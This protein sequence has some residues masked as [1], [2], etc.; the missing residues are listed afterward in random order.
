MERQLWRSAE[1]TPNIWL[2]IIICTHMW[3]KYQDWVEL[4]RMHWAEQ[5]LEL[6]QDWEEFVFLPTWVQKLQNTS[7]IG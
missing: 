2:N 5:D 1:F 6:P 3:R 4:P 7:G